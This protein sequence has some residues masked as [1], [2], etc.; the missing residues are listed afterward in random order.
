MRLI[1]YLG[2]DIG[3]VFGDRGPLPTIRA[4]YP[5]NFLGS[6]GYGIVR[7]CGCFPG[8]DTRKI[9]HWSALQESGGGSL[10]VDLTDKCGDQPFAGPDFAES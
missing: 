6:R 2:T 1:N 9:G 4:R 7:G 5:P 10:R 8:L 3:G